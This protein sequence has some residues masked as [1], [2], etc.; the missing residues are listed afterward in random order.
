MPV[1]LIPVYKA[2]HLVIEGCASNNIIAGVKGGAHAG[3]YNN[4]KLYVIRTA[5]PTDKHSVGISLDSKLAF[6]HDS[7]GNA[8]H[9]LFIR[10]P[11]YCSVLC[12]LRNTDSVNGEIR[13]LCC[14]C[15]RCQH[16][17][18]DNGCSLHCSY[19]IS[20]KTYFVNI[21]A[22]MVGSIYSLFGHPNRQNPLICQTTVV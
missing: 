5:N 13:F 19:C 9:S 18:Q 7:A 16:T 2:V 4:G 10:Q 11:Y 3:F 21:I 8:V 14:H 1:I 22:N 12:M 17:G 20:F 15:H 6:A